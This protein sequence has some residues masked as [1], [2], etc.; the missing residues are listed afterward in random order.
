MHRD[1]FTFT[2]TCST[3]ERRTGGALV[4][5]HAVGRL[6]AGDEASGSGLFIQLQAVYLNDK[7][8][9]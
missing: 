2:F 9:P 1:N 8:N 7:N 5:L 6:L 3:P 4:K